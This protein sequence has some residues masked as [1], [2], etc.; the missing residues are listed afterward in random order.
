MGRLKYRFEDQTN[1]QPKGNNGLSPEALY[2]Q[3]SLYDELA[4][5]RDIKRPVNTWSGRIYYGKIDRRQ[6]SIIPQP[7]T[8]KVIE[9]S[10]ARNLFALD[11]VVSAFEDFV[12]HMEKAVAMQAVNPLGNDRLLRVRAQQAYIDPSRLYTDYLSRMLDIFNSKLSTDRRN[13]IVDFPT[14][15]DA[16]VAHLKTVA[17]YT[18]ITQTN[19][20]LTQHV[21]ALS[22]GLVIA[23]DNGPPE[24]DKYKFKK[25]LD[26]PNWAFFVG[27]A[28][29][30]GFVID[31]NVPW[32]LTFD[33]FTQSS[34]KYIENRYSSTH[35][36]VTKDNFFDVYYG[37]CYL[38]EV[39]M[40]RNLILNSYRQFL[41][42]NPLREEIYMPAHCSRIQPVPSSGPLSADPF[43]VSGQ[44]MKVKVVEREQ[45]PVINTQAELGDKFMCDLYLDLR[46]IEAQ[47]PFRVAEKFYREMGEMYRLRPNQALSGVQNAATFVN[48]AYRDYIYNTN[49]LLYGSRSGIELLLGLDL[50]PPSGNIVKSGPPQGGPSN[51]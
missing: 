8:L 36:L 20:N 50:P 44:P 2:Y 48:L 29:K 15:R 28:K 33:L 10:A 38:S 32:R 23:I 7:S 9:S 41:R 6:N 12:A 40:L 19:Y 46:S 49:Y 11:C 37:R 47:K 4:Y 43:G 27:C 1:P 34:L 39:Q 35:G 5:P 17:A 18:P 30:Y 25:Y 24:D 22:S 45:K 3:R 16:Y 26:D 21:N 14:F 31:K 51:Y 13:K 42:L